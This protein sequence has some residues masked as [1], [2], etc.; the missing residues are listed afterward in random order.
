MLPEEAERKGQIMLLGAIELASWWCAMNPE[1]VAI[2]T[3]TQSGSLCKIAII[4]A[5]EFVSL[6]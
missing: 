6:S 4:N 5:N 3:L 2:V 1:N